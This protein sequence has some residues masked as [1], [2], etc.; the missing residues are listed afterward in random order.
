MN[1]V[2]CITVCRNN[3]DGL[4]KTV[5]S[6]IKQTYAL[7]ELII[8]DGASTDGTKNMFSEFEKECRNRK[9]KLIIISEPDSGIYNAMNK[10]IDVSTGDWLIFM[11]SGD[12]F[13]DEYVIENVFFDK[14]YDAFSVIY[15]DYFIKINKY[16]GKRECFPIEIITKKWIGSHQALF[17][18]REKLTRRH[19][20]EQYPICADYEW[21]LNS[22][23]SGDKVCFVSTPICISD[24]SGISNT[25][26]YKC[27]L[28]TE[29]LR[30]D[31][32]VPT[33]KWKLNI[34]K[35]YV[36]IYEILY[37]LLLKLNI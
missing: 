5:D 24:R 7:Y 21:Y 13:A 15:G 3:A 23:L 10:G 37:R 33:P 9:I 19:Y 35:P 2:S 28:E 12:V 11:N 16:I 27:F 31:L 4:K 8:V 29:R 30:A 1:K 25:A 18:K 34:K 14:N 26:I 36:K 20:Q 6:A 17:T 32:G 22:Y